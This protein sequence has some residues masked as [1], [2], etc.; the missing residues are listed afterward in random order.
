MKSFNSLTRMFGVITPTGFIVLSICVFSANAQQTMTMPSPTPKQTPSPTPAPKV[1]PTPADMNMPMPKPTPMSSTR[2]PQQNT[3]MDAAQMGGDLHIVDF[4]NG[5]GLPRWFMK[6]R[7][8]WP[9]L[10]HAAYRTEVLECLKELQNEGT[11][12]YTTISVG[13]S[14]AFIAHFRKSQVK[15]ENTV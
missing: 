11:G 4:W 8:R 9:A 10:F 15:S 1:T 5:V 7:T 2:D 12:K 3:H 6:L 13:T 14:Y